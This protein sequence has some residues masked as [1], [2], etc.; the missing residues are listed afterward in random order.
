MI[1]M[2]HSVES[3]TEDPY[4]IT[5][6]P[7]RFE[8]QLA[9]IRRRGLRGVAMR[10][11]LAA[12]ATGTTTGLVGLTFDDGYT[13][14]V[15]RVMPLL[16]RYNCT[17]TVYIVAGALGGYNTWDTPG[18]RKP[19]MT[20]DDVRRAADAGVEIGS[21]SLSHPRLP[22]TSDAELADE[23]GHSRAVLEGLA[24]VRV[25]GFCYPYGAA[26]AREID[27]VRAAGYGYACA[28][29]AAGCAGLGGAHSLPR[30]YI[31]D[32][33]SAPRLYAKWVRH[34]IRSRQVRIGGVR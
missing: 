10:E 6:R 1:L 27:A 13:D 18:P 11:L 32:R 8:R 20:A 7:E 5:V 24:G 28:V 26:G 12:R 25:D 4:R 22:A 2:Y 29:D 31:G 17:A 30:T 9:W 3:Y 34:G 23:V 21:H 14:F 16:A 33:D 19:L 15:T